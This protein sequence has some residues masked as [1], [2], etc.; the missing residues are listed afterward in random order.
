[1]RELTDAE[2]DVGLRR[3]EE[4]SRGE[5]P[6]VEARC[7]YCGA[8]M[9][10]GVL[11]RFNRAYGIAVLIVGILL[12]LFMSLLLGLPMVVIGASMGVA[13]RAVWTCRGCGVVVDRIRT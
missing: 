11:P 12:S 5:E 8:G 3:E 9:A 13:N 4:A 7:A 10:R 6:A 2:K 1:M